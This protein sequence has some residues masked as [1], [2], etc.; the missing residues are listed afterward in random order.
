MTGPSPKP[1]R[2]LSQKA[3]DA[4]MAEFFQT[5]HYFDEVSSSWYE[6]SSPPAVEGEN[7]D[8][9]GS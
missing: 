3:T 7:D 1:T 2:L 5:V 6:P 4:Q 8:E 9:D